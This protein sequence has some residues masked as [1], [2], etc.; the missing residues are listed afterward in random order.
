M[1]PYSELF[2]SVFSHIWN[3]YGEILRI[4]SECEKIWNRTTPMW[5]LFIWSLFTLQVIFYKYKIKMRCKNHSYK[6][7]DSNCIFEDNHNQNL[8]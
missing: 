2:W 3:E 7:G 5:T 4:Q 8:V 1:R 6:T